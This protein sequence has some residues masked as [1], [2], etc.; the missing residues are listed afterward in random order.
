MRLRFTAFAAVDV[1]EARDWYSEQG[2]SLGDRFEQALDDT[3]ASILEHPRAF[4]VVRRGTRRAM[5]SGAF[6]AYQVFYRLESTDVVVI[7]VIH[8]SRHPKH[9]KRRR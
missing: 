1:A 4:P 8:G 7:A 6:S 5:V 2:P 3:L 9:W